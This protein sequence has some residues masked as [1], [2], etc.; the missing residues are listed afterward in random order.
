MIKNHCSKLTE[1]SLDD[2]KRVVRAKLGLEPTVDV[3]LA[4]LRGERK[5]V[6]EDGELV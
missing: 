4:Q 3:E 5:I 6:L 2:T 1:T